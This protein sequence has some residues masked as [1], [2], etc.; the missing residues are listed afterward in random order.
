[1]TFLH[2]RQLRK[3]R[4]KDITAELVEIENKIEA[5]API[6][7]AFADWWKSRKIENGIELDLR[8]DMAH[9]RITRG[10]K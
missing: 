3:E 10:K 2:A 7:S 1:M 5:D 8:Y 9:P 4:A 6:T